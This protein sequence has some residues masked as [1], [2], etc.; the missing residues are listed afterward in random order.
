MTVFTATQP[1]TLTPAALIGLFNFLQ[2]NPQ[3]EGIPS[4]TEFK[5]ENQAHTIEID[6][7]GVGFS[8][9]QHGP[10]GGTLTS[11]QI[12]LPAGTL[13]YK[14]AGMAISIP[15]VVSDVNSGHFGAILNLF[16]GGNDNISGSPG[17]DYLNGFGGNDRIIGGLGDDTMRGGPG[18]DTFV[19]RAGFGH[20]RI[21]D[22][23]VGTSATGP[24]DTIELHSIAGLGSFAQVK[25]HASAATGHVVI[26]DNI[27]DT[28]TF[29]NLTSVS[30]L[31][32]YD[33]HF[34][35]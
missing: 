25:A 10:T 22:F 26:T 16:L 34:L 11:L 33:F 21:Q 18:N 2:H 8:F 17:G 19:F 32:K 27:G 9:N 29:T 5:V 23:T 15:T 20:D 12:N 31:H 13:A 6:L 7:K 14:F 3:F 28:I 30:Q 4:T 1:V 24:H 35:A